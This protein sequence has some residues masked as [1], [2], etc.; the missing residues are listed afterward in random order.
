MFFQACRTTA[1]PQFSESTQLWAKRTETL[2]QFLKQL[3]CLFLASRQKE[4]RI[5]A[6]RGSGP[7]MRQVLGRE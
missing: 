7:R 2:G 4:G 5:P 6:A 1:P 3:R